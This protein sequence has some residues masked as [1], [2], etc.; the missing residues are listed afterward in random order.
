MH[1]LLTRPEADV[2]DMQLR[3]EQLGCTVSCA[4]LLKIHC[5]D[6]SEQ[7]IADAALIVVTSRNGLRALARSPAALAKARALP[8]VAVGGATAALA[9]D[10]GF[11]SVTAGPGTGRE[12]VP[13]LKA[14]AA[15]H[16]GLIVHLAGDHLAFDLKSAVAADGIEIKVVPAYRSVAVDALPGGVVAALRRREIDAVILMSPRT[17]RVWA[18][19]VKDLTANS[20][21][22]TLTHLC[23]SDN[24]AKGLATL[25]ARSALNI[26]VASV[27]DSEDIIALVKRLAGEAKAE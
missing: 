6:I 1:I 8:L 26:A 15:A 18:E 25:A 14:V 5:N 22:A 27:P 20:D 11:T 4:P 3:L 12:L 13:I 17:A 10:L 16:P 24:V 2:K 21:L 19:L 7:V 9:R 23:L